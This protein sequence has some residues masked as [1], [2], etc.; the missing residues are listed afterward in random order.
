MVFS[1]STQF[2]KEQCYT[3]KKENQIG[4]TECTI[5]QEEKCKLHTST[6]KNCSP[7]KPFE[8][9]CGNFFTVYREVAKHQKYYCS[10]FVKPQKSICENCTA[11]FMS[12]RNLHI[13]QS[14]C[15]TVS[16][17]VQNND[18]AITNLCICVWC[19]TTFISIDQLNE[20]TAGCSMY[21]KRKDYIQ[22]ESLV[23]TP[24][25]HKDNQKERS[26]KINNAKTITQINAANLNNISSC[27]LN[28]KVINNEMTER[29][30][31]HIKTC[32]DKLN[33][34]VNKC[35]SH[36]INLK[37]S[38]VINK[39]NTH[40]YKKNQNKKDATFHFSKMI[41][42][43]EVEN[44]T[45]NNDVINGFIMSA[46][47]G[48]GQNIKKINYIKEPGDGCGKQSFF[49]CPCGLRFGKKKKFLIHQNR[50][51]EKKQIL[52]KCKLCTFRTFRI[53]LLKKHMLLHSNSTEN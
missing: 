36:Q 24:E 49:H 37:T 30:L 13:H 51:L 34:S 50:C 8:C 29:N 2:I 3:Q 16:E 17:F 7:M 43:L 31:D 39:K 19:K 48:E 28:N 26:P 11:V 41:H 6:C 38:K 10:E 27:S 23:S 9:I 18:P 35:K 53:M 15:K 1:N 46:K 33:V 21:P 20:H 52:H 32:K 14:N 47:P 25:T 5:F 42:S 12:K 44:S 22:T 4:C 40:C 45:S